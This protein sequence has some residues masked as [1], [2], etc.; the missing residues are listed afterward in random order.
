MEFSVVRVLQP[1]DPQLI[2]W[3]DGTWTSAHRLAGRCYIAIDLAYIE[4]LFPSMPMSSSG[5]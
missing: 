1:A 5:C 3:G 2:N 4:D